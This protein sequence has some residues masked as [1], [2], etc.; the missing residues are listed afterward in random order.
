MPARREIVTTPDTDV[1]PYDQQTSSSRTTHSMGTAV[2]GAVDEIRDQLVRLAA[3]E[4]PKARSADEAVKR[5]KR[6]LHQAVGAFRAGRG[7]DPLAT[8]R[9]TWNGDLADP[10][11]R[12]ACA[13]AMRSHAS[14]RE[15]EP[16]VDT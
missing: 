10:S 9:A 2:T 8:V 14:T 12:A 5:V 11:F 3:E 7:S 13:E 1:T 16:H 15:R 4:M 6:R